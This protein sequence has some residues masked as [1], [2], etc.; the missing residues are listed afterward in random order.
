M[1][2][3]LV[4]GH[5][6]GI[7]ATTVAV[8][9]AH[10]LAYAG[11]DVR[12]ERLA[13]DAAAAAD[14]AVFASVEFADARGTPIEVDALAAGPAHVVAEAPAGVDAAELAGRLRARL[15]LVTGPGESA[16]AKAA[17]VLVPSREH[18]GAPGGLSELDPP[19]RATVI[20]NH[21]R[22][23]GPLQLPE[24]RLLAAP[25]V[26]RLIEASR[27]RVVTRSAEGERAVCQ[28]IVVGAISHDSDEPYFRRFPRKAVVTRAEK[29]DIALSALRTDTA[30]LI[31]CGGSDPSPYLLDRVAAL[32]TTT[33]LVAP[34]GTVET[35]RDIEGTF[36]TVSFGGQAKI[37]R[38]GELMS[39]AFDDTLED[40]IAV[41]GV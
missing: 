3:I 14:A 24:D 22:R 12:L 19:A 1:T 5:E 34:E 20:V 16:P 6:P 33:V 2:V 15:V 26:G 32:G 28:H 35:V 10:R 39:A 18:P 31:L 4:A 27:A 25:T 36:G 38:I 37:D 9:L 7:G 40:L 41:G 23:A 21:A 8:G 13:G 29:V 30:C 17:P 11:R